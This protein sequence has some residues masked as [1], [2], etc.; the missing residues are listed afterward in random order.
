MIDFKSIKKIVINLKRREDR[1]LKF[2]E[3]MAYMDWDYEI[4]EAIDT[5]SY[6]GCALS[7]QKIAQDFLKSEDEYLLVMEDDIF[8]LPHAKKVLQEVE[9]EL[10]KVSWDFFHFGPSIHRPLKKYNDILVDLNNLPPKDEQKHRGIYG[11][12]AF[13]ITKQSAEI[14]ANWDTS[15]YYHNTHRQ[16]PIDQYF[17]IVLYKM[18]RAF[19]PYL[20]ITTQRDFFSDINQTFDLNHYRLTYNWNVYLPDKL[21]SQYL[22]FEYCYKNR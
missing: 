12:T 1:L 17:D 5:N 3:E 11:T 19:C 13:V 2:R 15:K 16:I 9:N 7:H 10:N 14:I 4:F 18:S 22:D 20:T 6:E 21:P 8:F